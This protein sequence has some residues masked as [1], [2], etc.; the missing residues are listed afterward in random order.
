[1]SIWA[2]WGCEGADFMFNTLMLF[3]FSRI[4]AYA[5]TNTHALA[6]CAC[7]CACVLASAYAR[8]SVCEFV[9]VT[10]G[11]LA[12]GGSYMLNHAS[13]VADGGSVCLMSTPVFR[14]RMPFKV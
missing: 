13:R 8:T 9:D 12:P 2:L 11:A 3:A 6:A 4:H 10:S 14:Q 7:A 1:M 5:H